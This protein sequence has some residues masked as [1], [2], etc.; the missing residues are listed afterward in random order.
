[1]HVIYGK[2]QLET[3]DTEEHQKSAE[4]KQSGLK[5]KLFIDS[6][7]TDKSEIHYG[8]CSQLFQRSH[9]IF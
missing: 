7:S 6:H 3:L 5:I 2:V 1:M 8:K 4:S 9:T